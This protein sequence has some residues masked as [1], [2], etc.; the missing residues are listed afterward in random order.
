[1]F[2]K[3]AATDQL[4]PSRDR[5]T[6]QLAPAALHPSAYQYDPDHATSPPFPLLKMEDGYVLVQVV[7]S[8]DVQR[9]PC[10]EASQ[11]SPFHSSPV[12]AELIDPVLDHVNPS[13]D[14][15]KPVTPVCD[16]P[17]ASQ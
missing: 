13:N 6:V 16:D 14:R 4:A 12:M 9:P 10:D 15:A 3:V 5:T 7:P 11:T 1:M 8:G 17:P 2:G